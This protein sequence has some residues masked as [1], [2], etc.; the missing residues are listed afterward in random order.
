M[1]ANKDQ[2]W[3]PNSYLQ[4]WADPNRPRHHE[5]F[6][7]LFNRHGGEHRRRNPKNVFNMPD[8]YTI[9]SGEERDLSLEQHFGRLERDFV[10]VRGLIEIA[11]YG[12]AS[13]VAA[14]YGFVAAMLARPPH[15]IDDMKQQW[16]SIVANARTIRIDPEMR[17]IPSLGRGGPRL[18]LTEAQ[19][20]A[21]D[22]M[23]TWFPH[24][25]NAHIRAL[26][27]LFGCDVLINGSPHPFLTSDNPAV[28]YFPPIDVEVRRLPPPRG[29]GSRGC[30]ITLPISP[31]HALLF[32]HK[33]P[34]I[35]DWLVLDWE[36]VF[37][38][39][40]RTITRARTTIVSD[41]SDLFFV[42]TILEL[43]AEVTEEAPR[44]R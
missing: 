39:N 38:I 29:L 34:G 11:D 7:H 14:L 1:V 15:K 5:P 19:R 43:V 18:T 35:H 22:P 32:T 30:E 40:F 36:G 20:M 41:R 42:Q 26:S 28:V 23:G 3:V 37:D 27:K 16:S 9:F 24:S 2:H 8:L 44:G 6:I 10:R 4:A 25:L 13:E 17:P 31:T 12:G 33:P 21:D